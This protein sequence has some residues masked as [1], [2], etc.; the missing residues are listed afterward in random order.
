MVYYEEIK[1]VIDNHILDE[2]SRGTLCG[3]VKS[4][5]LPL[6]YNNKYYSIV[7]K[8]LSWNAKAWKANEIDAV[9]TDEEGY[10]EIANELL[11]HI[12]FIYDEEKI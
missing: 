1:K 4:L 7:V 9:G 3:V 11:D 5:N 12:N 8:R 2:I 6:F 10:Y